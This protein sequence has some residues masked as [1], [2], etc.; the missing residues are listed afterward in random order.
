MFDAARSLTIAALVGA[1]PAPAQDPPRPFLGRE[2]AHTMH[3]TGAGWLMRATREDEENGLMLRSWLAARPGQSVCDLGCGN[4]YHTLPLARSVGAAGTVYAVDIQPEMLTMLATRAEAEKLDNL[5]LIEAGEDD[6]GL[7]PGS[8]DLVLLVDV[9]HELSDPAAVMGHV[10]R[11]LRQDGRCV[12]VEFRA[13]DPR[14]PIKPEHT[15]HKAQMVREMAE[16]GFACLDDYDGLPWQHAMAF[17]AAERRPDGAGP[18]DPRHAEREFARAFAAAASFGPDTELRAFLRSGLDLDGL[19]RPAPKAHVELRGGGN[20]GVIAQVDGE[21]GPALEA[22]LARDAE[23]RLFVTAC[24]ESLS[25]PRQHGSRRAFFAMHTGTGGGPPDAQAELVRELG[26]DGLACSIEDLP[27][28]RDA[29]ERRGLDAISGYAVLDLAQTV[30]DDDA[31]AAAI[32]PLREAMLALQDGPGQLWLALQHRKVA[33]RDARGLADAERAMSALLA[34][35]EATGVEIA[36]YPHHGFWLETHDDAVRI[37]ERLTHRRLGLCFNLCHC[38][39]AHEA[40][41]PG[42]ALR[43]CKG[44]LLAVTL[45]G[46]FADGADFGQWIRPLGQG[47]VDTKALLSVLDEIGYQGPVALQGYGLKG[48]AADNL[49]A[50]MAAWR[51]LHAR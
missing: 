46:A 37:C 23:G 4:G 20:G 16:H 38:L 33:P 51:E 9:Y 43:R 3:W 18:R 47:D 44:K 49:R 35:A 10:R 30:G 2:P 22:W 45:H 5:R 32:A 27:A 21:I 13:D 14:V 19:R 42:D 17:A 48:S 36:L 24:A 40:A 6:P 50:S 39:A 7:P 12:L 1:L 8:C 11:A 15:M 41:D 28:A 25:E 29:C 34:V 31:L 26:Y